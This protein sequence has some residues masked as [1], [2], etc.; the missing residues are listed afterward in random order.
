[1]T[2][3]FAMFGELEDATIVIDKI[4]NMSRGYGFVTYRRLGDLD[5]VTNLKHFISGIELECKRAVPLKRANGVAQ[6]NTIPK[7]VNAE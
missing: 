6:Q 7:E 4:T 1:M 3:Y 5:R 2:K